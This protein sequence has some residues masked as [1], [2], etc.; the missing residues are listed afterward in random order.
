M[1]ILFSHTGN[2]LSAWPFRLTFS[3]QEERGD[4]WRGYGNEDND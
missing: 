3:L 1:L 2:E 4:A